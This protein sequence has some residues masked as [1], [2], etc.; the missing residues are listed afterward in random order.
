M[1][2]PQQDSV[3]LTQRFWEFR[4][5]Q[6]SM[7]FEKSFPYYDENFLKDVPTSAL[8]KMFDKALHNEKFKLNKN[9]TSQ[10]K[11]RVKNVVIENEP[12]HTYNK[13]KS[14]LL[15]IKEQVLI[16]I[17]REGIWYFFPYKAELAPFISRWVPEEI[18][19]KFEI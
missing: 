11:E 6:E 3:A 9:L 15:L 19:T 17:K 12:N 18:F 8:L 13:R 7:K 2:F 5:L 10:E 16:V 1:V 4:K 14:E